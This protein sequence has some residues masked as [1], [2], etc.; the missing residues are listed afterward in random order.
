MS[1]LFYTLFDIF[2]SFVSLIVKIITYPL[3][4]IFT[5]FLPS[6]SESILDL[7]DFL[8]SLFD[9]T[10]YALDILPTQVKTVLLFIIT[11]E[12]S[13]YFIYKNTIILFRLWFLI[14]KLKFW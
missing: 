9:Y 4:L 1:D 11:C 14:R 5:T 8:N 2:I 12:I 3:N 10:F 6:F 13:K 7:T